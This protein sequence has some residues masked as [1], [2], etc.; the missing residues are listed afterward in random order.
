MIA[1]LFE[2]VLSKPAMYVGHGSIVRV[3]SFMDGYI[4]ATWKEGKHDNS[5]A[6][7]GFQKFVENRFELTRTHSWENLISFMTISEAEAFEETKTLWAQYKAQQEL[8]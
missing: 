1:E 2:D 8:N 4:H 3:K 6:Y 7:F 5:D